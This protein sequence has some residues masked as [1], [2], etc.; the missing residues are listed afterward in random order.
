M[1]PMVRKRPNAT[2]ARLTLLRSVGEIGFTRSLAREAG[3][4]GITVN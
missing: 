1:G 2:L 3:R 4:L